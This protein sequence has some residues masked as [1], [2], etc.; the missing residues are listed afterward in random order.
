MLRFYDPDQ[1]SVTL[2]GTDIRELDPKWL[3]SQIGIV[4]QEPTLFAATIYDNI[5]YGNPLA[6]FD[7][8]RS[9]VFRRLSC[10]QPKI[11]SLANK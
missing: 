2:D 9:L 10:E 5:A 7:D 4:S 11:G 1:G 8:V 6:N 3:R